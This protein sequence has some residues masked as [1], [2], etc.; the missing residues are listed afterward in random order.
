MAL[1][2]I[3]VRFDLPSHTM[4]IELNIVVYTLRFKWN[5]RACCWFMDIADAENM[6]IVNGIAV[7]S[8]VDMI[9]HIKNDSLPPGLF[10][11]YDETGQSR[12]P[13][14]ETFGN[15]VKLF[16]QEERSS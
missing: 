11:S 4:R 5:S 16:Y 10:L 13:D 2:N 12:D 8:N 3:P 9:G 6:D 14:R 15:E 1:I 7:R